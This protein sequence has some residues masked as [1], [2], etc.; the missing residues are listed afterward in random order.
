[1]DTRAGFHCCR[2]HTA[3]LSASLS[4]LSLNSHPPSGRSSRRQ[5]C[6]TNLASVLDL[7]AAVQAR[8]HKALSAIIA[9]HVYVGCVDDRFSLI[10]S[11]TR[12]YVVDMPA[13]TREAFYQA[14]VL[15]FGA[16][17]PINLN[18]PFPALQLLRCVLDSPEAGWRPADGS[19]DD[20]AAFAAALLQQHAAM[21]QEYF[22]IRIDSEGNVAA[23]PQLIPGFVPAMQLL[24]MFLLRLTT[25][26]DWSVEA[27]CLNGICKQLAAFYCLRPGVATLHS[28]PPSHPDNVQ[29]LG[30]HG[31]GSGV[32]AADDCMEADE[33][34]AGGTAVD[35][36]AGADEACCRGTCAPRLEQGEPIDDVAEAGD[37]A[38]AAAGADVGVDVLVDDAR[39]RRKR[40][41]WYVCAMSL[42]LSLHQRVAQADAARSAA[43]HPCLHGAA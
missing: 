33:T 34:A 14:A 31:A 21:L 32:A 24:P 9:D 40:L 43:R 8:A 11:G 30:N 39:A 38:A 35:V 17:S 29:T 10:Q 27:P 6:A 13:F 42:C 22:C 2:L 1:M 12:L 26:V 7:R 5:G 18:P 19:K 36:R 3:L 23:L 28:Q 25:E 4:H 37:D 16:F 15:G 41:H 20:V